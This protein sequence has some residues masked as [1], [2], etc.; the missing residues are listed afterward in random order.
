MAVNTE[1]EIDRVA[2]Q[3]RV[4]RARGVYGA[5]ATQLLRGIKHIQEEK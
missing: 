1:T 5:G 3:A 2:R 4:N